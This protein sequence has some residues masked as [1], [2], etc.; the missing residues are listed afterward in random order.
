[1]AL[2][3]RRNH[4]NGQSDLFV[5]LVFVVRVPVS[6]VF[7]VGVLCVGVGSKKKLNVR[8]IRTYRNITK[9]KEHT[10]T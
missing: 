2:H 7:D 5:V 10:E 6:S 3:A 4:E 1:M 8:N 9:K